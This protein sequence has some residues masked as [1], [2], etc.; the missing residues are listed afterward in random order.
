SPTCAAR[1]APSAPRPATST[2]CSPGPAPPCPG[3]PGPEG[4]GPGWRSSPPAS[5]PSPRRTS[6]GS[7]N[8]RRRRPAD[9]AAD[10]EVDDDEAADDEVDARPVWPHGPAEGHGRAAAGH[11]G[12]GARADR[13]ARRLRDDLRA[14]LPDDGVLREGAV[15]LREVPGQG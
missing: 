4:R 15:P 2:P 1:S 13:R 10:D 14:H 8:S 11:G 7:P 9:E 5:A 12:D 6:P 3:C